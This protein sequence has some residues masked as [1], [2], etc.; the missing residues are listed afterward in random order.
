MLVRS[1]VGDDPRQ[2]DAAIKLMTDAAV[3]G[4]GLV[5]LCEFSWVLRSRYKVSS[6]RI[7]AAIRW[8]LKADNVVL[9]RG[10]VQ[11]GLAMLDVGGDFADG[12]IAYEGEWLG[13]GVFVSF[14]KKAVERLTS[15][16][17]SAQLL[18]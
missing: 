2:A 12:V 10:A 6:Q 13:G 14:D 4:V 1:A 11:A 17:K 7:G 18:A 16:G 3:V 8:L 9:N 15:Q 5:A